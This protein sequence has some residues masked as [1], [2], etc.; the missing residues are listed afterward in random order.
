MT[1]SMT[2][3]PSS[4]STTAATCQVYRRAGDP[5]DV[6]FKDTR[7][8]PSFSDWVLSILKVRGSELQRSPEKSPYSEAISAFKWGSGFCRSQSSEQALAKSILCSNALLR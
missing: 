5:A 3:W 2:K 8:E 1:S 6:R 4:R 7:E